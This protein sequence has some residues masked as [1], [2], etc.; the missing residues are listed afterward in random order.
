MKFLDQKEEVIDLELTPTGI[1]LLQLGSFKPASYCFFDDDVIYDSRWAGMPSEVQS[2][3]EER[4][5]DMPRLQAIGAKYSVEDKIFADDGVNNSIAEYDMF[6]AWDFL[7]SFNETQILSDSSYFTNMLGGGAGFPNNTPTLTQ[8][9][10]NRLYSLDG[11]VGNMGYEAG[12]SLPTWNIEFLKSRLTG[13][14]AVTGSV[15][16]N[17]YELRTDLQYRLSVEVAET[18]NVVEADFEPGD[19]LHSIPQERVGTSLE[20]LNAT[21]ISLDGTY[22]QVVDDYLFLKIQ[23]EN[24]RYFN[25]NFEIEVYYIEDNTDTNDLS[26]ERR[27]FFDNTSIHMTDVKAPKLNTHAAVGESQEE[28]ISQTFVGYYLDVLVDEQIP[29]E[30]YCRALEE[31]VTTFGYL[32]KQM[33]TCKGTTGKKIG[34]DPY[35]MPDKTTEICE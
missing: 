21:T 15:G 7:S 18:D 29:N 12:N 25:E 22:I 19:P 31:D 2:Q 35:G 32:D 17:I 33:F 3:I 5:Q 6:Q 28:S 11:P 10:R 13:S 34:S 20:D 16:E 9:E 8:N 23:E 24:T 14:V 30:I 4:I 26:N 27:L 1:R